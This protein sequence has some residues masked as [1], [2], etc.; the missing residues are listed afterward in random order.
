[1]RIIPRKDWFE[2]TYRIIDYGRAYCPAR[3]HTHEAC[4]LTK[5]LAK[6]A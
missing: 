2:A 5:A 3:P 1:M 4:P 6:K